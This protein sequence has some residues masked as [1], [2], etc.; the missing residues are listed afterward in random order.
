MDRHGQEGVS[1]TRQETAAD[2]LKIVR[3]LAAEVHPHHAPADSIRL[4]SS[5]ERD[6]GLDS[7]SKIELLTRLE[8][9]FAVTLHDRVFADSESPRDLW[10]AVMGAHTFTTPGAARIVTRVEVDDVDTTPDSAR[11]LVDV[12]GYYAGE[13]PD[14]VHVQFYQ[15]EG[16]G[17]RLTYGSLAERA[18]RLATGLQRRGLQSGEPVAI[19]L[20]TGRDYFFAFY[21][22]MMAGG[23]PVPIYPPARLSQIEDHLRRHRTILANCGTAT[24][25]TIAEATAFARLLKS[26]VEKMRHVVT[27]EHLCKE[28]PAH[29]EDPALRGRDI[30]FLQYTSGS[31]GDPKGVVL[32]HAN[33]LANIRVI[34]TTLGVDDTDVGVSWL[35]LYHDMGLIGACMCSLYYAFPLVLLSPLE[36]ISR[37]ERWFW[38]IHRYRGTLSAAPNF[39]YEYSLRK[40]KDADLAGLDLSS[41]RVGCN[42]AET[43][44]PDTIE[45]FCARFAQYG[46]RRQTM[47]PVYGLAEC[48]LGVTFPPPDR[49]PLVDS[50]ERDTFARTGRAMRTQTD[51]GNALRFVACGHPLT[52]HEVRIVDMAGRELPERHDGRLQFRGPSATSGYFR[53]PGATRELFDGDW[54]D[55]GDRAYIAE[56]DVYITGRTKDVIIRAG[57]NI[58]PSELEEAIGD[59][60]GVR[61]GSI[62]AFGRTDP[63]TNVEQLVVVAETN[64]TDT[65]AK[66]RIR[67]E[68]NR[69]AFDLTGVSADDIVLVRPRTI[70]KTSS[71]KIRRRAN[72]ELYE[73]GQL[74]RDRGAP[75]RQIAR[76]ALPGLSAESRRLLRGLRSILYAAWAWSVL[77]VVGVVAWL[78]VLVL[79]G[80]SWRWAAVRLALRVA[81]FATR[82][83]ISIQG[84]ENV[85]P[86]GQS[87]FVS[88]H[89]SYIDS[90]VL[91][92]MLPRAVSYVAKAELTKQLPVRLFLERLHTEFVER[93]DKQRGIEDAR[94]IG[95]RAKE[96]RSLL[97]YPEGGLRRMPGLRPFQMGA[98]VSAADAGVPIVPVA[99]R[100]TRSI[101]RP[102]TWFPRPGSISVTIG[103][104]IH[105]Q[106]TL[107]E[108]T[109]WAAAT[110]LSQEAR[111][112][113]LRHCGEPDLARE[114]S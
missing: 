24:L 107:T 101:L 31:T 71:G 5:L 92:A 40:L 63:Q 33:L 42:G 83:R 69:L 46:F 75:W 16:E 7:L 56:G 112:H 43:V 74:E 47:Y 62:V 11:T 54:L 34:G 106:D 2:V 57:R 111:D 37:P 58:Y 50:I 84:L 14:R 79:P 82:H 45:R 85:D 108:D 32:T 39:A 64:E 18:R 110:L 28:D 94:R 10:R 99:V 36:F 55:S 48:S 60:D 87:V 25:I 93:F 61:R 30:A 38:A 6:V 102:G 97:F 29:Y 22:V 109:S 49:A 20:P 53:N 52:G 68:I 23:I 105:P 66:R 114:R 21:G 76:V 67:R 77:G 17:N 1:S 100:G 73:R 59:V 88:N 80:L 113:I 51:D 91:V 81:F 70:L 96:G 8:K 15:D 95:R 90:L 9:R 13:S 72:R 98:F 41:W 89:A 104:P 4:D 44:S 65:D 86:E 103:K 35:P 3:D 78:L 12:L 27:V 19:M 26:Q